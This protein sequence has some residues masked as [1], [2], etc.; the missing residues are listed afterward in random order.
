V[1]DKSICSIETCG[2]PVVV[3]GWCETH[4]GRWKRHGDPMFTKKRWRGSTDPMPVAKI[5]TGCRL[6]LPLVAFSADADAGTGVRA[7][8]RDCSKKEGA[9]YRAANLEKEQSRARRYRSEN[10]TAA[11]ERL[12]RWRRKNPGTYRAAATAWRRANPEKIRASSARRWEGQ[13]NTPKARIHNAIKA[14]IHQSI[15]KGSKAGQ[16]TQDLLGYSYEKLKVHLER[17]FANGM[18]WE[19]YGRYGWHIDHILPVVS[20]QFETPDDPEFR[21]CWALSNLRPLWST[22]NH[23]KHSKRLH[24][25]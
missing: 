19:N 22:E 17:Q 9:A 14:S 23:E 25:L 13:S 20:F 21:A 5:C 12:R 11:A 24:L 4:Y 18:S 2:K 8:C 7:K 15:I 6:D 10:A 3:R 16:R 1:A